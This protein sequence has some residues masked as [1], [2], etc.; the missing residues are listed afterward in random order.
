MKTYHDPGNIG[1]K[2][3]NNMGLFAAS[4]GESM[5]IM[6]GSVAA[7]RKAECWSSS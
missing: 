3:V 7:G 4:V 5:T 6:V 2:A 1:K